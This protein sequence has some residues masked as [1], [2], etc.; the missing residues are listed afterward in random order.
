MTHNPTHNERSTTMTY[1]NLTR[2]LLT[3]EPHQAYAANAVESEATLGDLL[4]LIQDAVAEYGA[5]ARIV[6][7]SPG[8]RYGAAYGRL[9]PVGLAPAA[10]TDDDL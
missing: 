3:I 5:D 7:Y 10:D 2:V 8:D 6:T 1:T 4:D 9:A